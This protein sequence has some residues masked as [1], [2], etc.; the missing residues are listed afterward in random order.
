MKSFLLV[1]LI[2]ISALLSFSTTSLAR[3]KSRTFEM[4]YTAKI[5][6]LPQDAKTVDIW[7]P[8]PISDESQQILEMKVESPYPAKVNY[9]KEFGNGILHLSPPP[10][11]EEFN[12]KMIFKVKREEIRNKRLNKKVST[13]DIIDAGQFSKYLAPSKYAVINKK[14]KEFAE[15]AT[16]GK[17]GIAQMAK[18][19]YDFIL[20]NMAYNKKVPGWGQGDVNRLCFNLSEGTEG[21]GNCTDFHS[22]FGSMMRS[23]GIPVIFEM[24]FPLITG[25]DLIE[26]KKGGYHCWA[27]FYLPGSGW[28]PVDISEADKAPRKKDY[29]FG[30]ICEDR[31]RFSRGRDILLEPKQRGERLN[32]FGPDPYIEIDGVSSDLF[33]RTISYKDI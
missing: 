10:G 24:G 5:K 6:P 8:Y 13:S 26:G 1:S 18:G 17:K 16:S 23:M 3:T 7:I 28:I 31:I 9:D 20:E 25:K 21:T 19:S 4:T 27:K 15:K 33:E 14:V 32:Y 2:A 22:L 30:S 29:F 12:I 11:A